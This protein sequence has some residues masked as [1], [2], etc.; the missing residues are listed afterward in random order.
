MGIVEKAQ[1]T[2]LDIDMHN[3]MCLC[4]TG[5]NLIPIVH[6]GISPKF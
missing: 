1:E 3:T 6:P 5:N 2:S 4:Q